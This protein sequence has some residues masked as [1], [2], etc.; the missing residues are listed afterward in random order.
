VRAARLGTSGVTERGAI[1]RLVYLGVALVWYALTWG[2]RALRGRC[3]VLCYHGVGAAQRERFRW[4]MRH[5][6][7]RAVAAESLSAPGVR[8]VGG[9]SVCVTFD[10]AFANLR[11][12][13]LP[14]VR[15]LRIPI[16]VFA[17]TECL[18]RTPAWRMEYGHPEVAEPTMSAS[19]LREAAR[20]AGCVFGSHTATHAALAELGPA[21]LRRE[22]R[23]SAAALRALV[24]RPVEDL[25][26]PYGS[27]DER[28]REEAL[29]AGYRR[30]FSL[31]ACLH[32]GPLGAGV[33]GRFSVSPDTWPIEFWLTTAGAYGWQHALRRAIARR[34]RA[35]RASAATAPGAP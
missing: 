34:R 8:A 4:Q 16:T 9:P 20:E 25:A 17:V 27:Y 35:P 32:P 14:A 3:V 6:A 31:D 5:V 10:D 26:F 29:A 2:G 19:D 7:G 28:V 11:E 24:P 18:G 15:E 12:N 13:A 21:D 30:L 1:V 23:D 22:L 33:I